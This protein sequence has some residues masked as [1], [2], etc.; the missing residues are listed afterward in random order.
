[1]TVL[2]VSSDRWQWQPVQVIFEFYQIVI[3]KS[4]VWKIR[5]LNTIV[6]NYVWHRIKYANI[7]EIGRDG[8]VTPAEV[9]AGGFMV[10]NSILRF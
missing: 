9:V 6:F 2:L 7:Y 8:C 10:M 1:M 5:N 3:H 4:V